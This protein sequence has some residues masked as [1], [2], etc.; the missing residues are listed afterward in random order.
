M[1]K[2]VA[3]KLGFYIEMYKNIFKF[4]IYLSKFVNILKNIL[5][6]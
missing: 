2:F 4:N 3:H 5:I 1:E 6:S